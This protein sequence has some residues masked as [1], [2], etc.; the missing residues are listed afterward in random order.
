M[1][2]LISIFPALAALILSLPA[3]ASD[4][5]FVS[6]KGNDSASGKAS[7]PLATL[8]AAL[9]KA[10][11]G[12]TI[13][14]DEGI[15]RIS[16]PIEIKASGISIVGAGMG[17]TFISGAKRL[18]NFKEYAKGIW[19]IDLSDEGFG[20]GTTRQLF[21]NG[22]RAV[23]A[24]TPNGIEC[25][26]TK[27]GAE[28]IVDTVASRNAPRQGLAVGSIDL[29][30]EQMKALDGVRKS[31]PLGLVI[32][33]LHKWDV[34]KRFVWSIDD[35][36]SK[37][38]FAENIQKPWNRVWEVSQFY[39]EGDRSFLDNAG[40]YF[41]DEDEKRIYYIPRD[42]EDIED[43]FAEIPATRQFLKIEDSRNISFRDMTF[44]YSSLP[45]SWR[46]LDPSQGAAASDASIM[47]SS[48]K[49]ISFT[50][51]E[52]AH[53]GNYGIWFREGCEE[54]E[55]RSCLIHDLG[56][57]GVKIGSMNLSDPLT[58]N[59]TVD[60]CIIRDGCH[61]IECG[62]GVIIFHSS[63]NKITHNEICDFYYTGV[64]V[65]WVWGYT[66]SPAKR[67]SIEYNHI[68]H[69]GWGLLSD[70]AAVYT[71][72]LSEGTVVSH[73]VIHDI[74][75]YGYGGW[76]LYTDEG[77]TGITMEDNLVYRCKSGGFHQHYGENNII[78][79]NIFINQYQAQLE[80][81]RVEDHNSFDFVSNI[82]CYT[83][84]AM[85]GHSWN[86]VHFTAD[87]NLYW[88][89]GGEV[90]FNGL[91]LK[92][93]RDSTGKDL[94]SIIA[95]PKFVNISTGDFRMRN[96]KALRRI[97]FKQFNWT[98]AGVYGSESW[99]KLAEYDPASSRQFNKASDKIFSNQD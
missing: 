48:S 62:E 35:A 8:D 59:V 39:L 97:G 77:S 89:F 9:K 83:G 68:H 32:T 84:G 29:D 27:G 71:L 92:Q 98:E 1:T 74:L 64:S 61:D 23:L 58:R 5:I 85:W 34:T 86:K 33:L 20:F 94:H 73:N 70:M 49:G 19:Y 69:I 40:E 87:K 65:G 2:R 88:H 16:R 99:K 80:A 50:D 46:G 7:W 13:H 10:G 21:V 26:K 3:N 6:P 66:P 53:T 25:F 91:T 18:P 96:S 90:S 24:R 78:R 63:D 12:A 4:D 76:G 41:Y 28:T 51:C 31:A 72:G 15:Y 22:R 44:E 45:L 38:Y 79:N 43:S 75:S 14:L 55:V 93:W 36:K 52:I 81:T 11:E 37:I 95:D 67:N 82:V 30:A 57:G 60:N 47:I 56:I 42:G 17:R 54:C